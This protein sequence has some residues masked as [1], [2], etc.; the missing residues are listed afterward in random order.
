M[1]KQLLTIAAV[2]ALAACGKA[3]DKPTNQAAANQVQPKKKAAYCFF[4]DA[5]MKGWAASRDKDGN[6]AVTG[7]AY[8]SDSRYQ[9]VFAPAE[10]TGATAEIAPTIQNNATGYGA[11][12]N[13]WDL[14]AAI[15]NSAAV[16]TVKVI[17]GQKTLAELQVPAKA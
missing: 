15:P 7:K 8:R 14:K 16:Q 10:V 17:C 11:P 3:D 1:Y 12:D 9:A 13:W 6:I 4:K 2:T 5:E